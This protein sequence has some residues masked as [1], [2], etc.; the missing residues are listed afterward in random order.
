MGDRHMPFLSL[1]YVST[2][3]VLLH[4]MRNVRIHVRMLTE[5]CCG[6]DGAESSHRGSRTG[7]EGNGAKDAGRR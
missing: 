3:R 4:G 6:S 2:V 7:C 1:R 5:M